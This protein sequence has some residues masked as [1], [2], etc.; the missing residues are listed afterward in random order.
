MP[1]RRESYMDQAKV[2]FWITL[3]D[4]GCW[5]ICFWCMYRISKKQNAVLAELREQA[6]RIERLSR[7]EHA[8]I[9]EVHPQVTDIKA[10]VEQVIDEIR[11]AP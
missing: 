6:E 9:K 8:L 2:V 5:V 10:G 3:S 1:N 11:D 4:A 7:E